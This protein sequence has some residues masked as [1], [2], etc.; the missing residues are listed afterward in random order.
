[1]RLNK[2]T[3]YKTKNIGY[4]G[5]GPQWCSR[6]AEP[7]IAQPGTLCPGFDATPDCPQSAQRAFWTAASRDY[8]ARAS[9]EVSIMLNATHTPIFAPDT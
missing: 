9:G 6:E 1:M 3:F 2:N 8:G 7:G 5:N 4:I